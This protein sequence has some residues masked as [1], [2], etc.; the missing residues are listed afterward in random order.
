MSAMRQLLCSGVGIY[1]S[2][3]SLTVWIGPVGMGKEALE[4]AKPSFTSRKVLDDVALPS[5]RG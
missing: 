5:G 1:P 3:V 4:T 2:V